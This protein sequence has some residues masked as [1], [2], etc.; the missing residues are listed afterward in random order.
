MQEIVQ[1]N[2][3]D[4]SL[5]QI[6]FSEK[7][8][9]KYKL[10]SIFVFKFLESALRIKACGFDEL[11]GCVTCVSLY[12]PTLRKAPF[13]VLSSEVTFLKLSISLTKMFHTFNLH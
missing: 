8:T 4:M 13:V 12:S 9:M 1:R 3:D 2:I 7:Q 11:P 10:L 5:L 6:V